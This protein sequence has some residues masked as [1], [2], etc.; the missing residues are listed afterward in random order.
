[1]DTYDVVIIGAGIA[2]ASAAFEIA[3]DHSV[4]I[5]E[6]ESRPGYHTSG[7]SAA[8]F[9][10]TYGNS[11]IQGLT[12]GSRAFYEAPPPGFA[13]HK[14]L[15]PRGVAY[16]ARADQMERLE[17]LIGRVSALAPDAA[18]LSRAELLARVPL[19][20][21]DYVA[22]G[23]IEPSAMDIDI[24]ALHD[25]YLRG[26]KARGAALVCDAGLVAL[27]PGGGLWHVRTSAGAWRAH[28][29]VNA[30]GAWADMVAGMAGAAPAGLVP[31][32]RT[33]MILALPDGTNASTWPMLTDT[34][35]QFYFK[36]DAGRLLASPGDETPMAPHDVQPDELDIAV[37]IDRIQQAADLPVRRVVRAWAGLR[38]FVADKTPVVGFDP[39]VPGFFWLAGQGGYGFQTA[40]AMGRLAAS[41][42]AGR[43]VPHDLAARGV[44]AGTLAPGR[45]SLSPA[46]SHTPPAG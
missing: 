28:I 27:E 25:G 1:M 20:K 30:A 33:A 2:G 38:S 39:A 12:T 18:M 45:A 24:A 37:C 34:D 10:E 40:P 42:L 22:G 32:R 7:R 3:A 19:L 43:A 29:A 36:P 8:V 4:L 15:S 35:E 41:L 13:D 5:L 14:L 31:K 16:V 44:T 11:T 21:P 26:A 23:A 9:T 6:G 46:R 17:A